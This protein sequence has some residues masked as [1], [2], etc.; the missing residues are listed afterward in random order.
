L[1]KRS[2]T[3]RRRFVDELRLLSPAEMRALFPASSLII[4]RLLGLPKSIL[5][6]KTD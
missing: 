5:A 6:L 4:E 2:E 3:E 1:D